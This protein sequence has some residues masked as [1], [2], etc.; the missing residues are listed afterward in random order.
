ML[1]GCSQQRPIP[2]HRREIIDR[3][4]ADPRRM[5]QSQKFLRDRII[6]STP[7]ADRSRLGASRSS[8]L[9]TCASG[10]PLGSIFTIRNSLASDESEIFRRCSTTTRLRPVGD[11]VAVHQQPQD[12]QQ[13]AEPAGH[14][15]TDEKSAENRHEHDAR[16]GTDNAHR[17]PEVSLAFSR[18]TVL[19]AAGRLARTH[20]MVS[21]WTIIQLSDAEGEIV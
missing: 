6:Q 7:A 14:G 9:Q 21:F 4:I 13:R 16:Y 11:G 3:E 1:N 10:E 19:F 17:P 15:Q 20:A 12:R 8:S 2:A 5:N 18:T